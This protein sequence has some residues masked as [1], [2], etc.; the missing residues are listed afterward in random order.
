[1]EREAFTQSILTNEQSFYRIA[2]T[3][4]RSDSDCEDAIHNAVLNAFRNL[5]SLREDRYFK[6]WFIRILLNECYKISRENR[7][8]LPAEELVTADAAQEKEDYSGLYEAVS[9]LPEKI[10]L[11]IVLHYIEDMKIEDVAKVLR[12]PK[13]TVKSRLNTGRRLLRE[14]LEDDYED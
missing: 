10:R 1:M 11:A 9:K 14:Y 12:I 5:S 13:G 6:T 8:Y 4:L 3:V 7:K 2:K